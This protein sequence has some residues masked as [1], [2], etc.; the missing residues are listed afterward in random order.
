MR[1]KIVL[2]NGGIIV[3]LTLL[4][5]FLLRSSLDS[6]LSNPV[7]R[8]R[9][10]SR[11]LQS[12]ESRLLLDALK[13]ERWLDRMSSRSGVIEVFAAGTPAARS[14]AATTEANRLRDAAVAD[15]E[16][17][18]MG[19][20]LV[21]LVDADG[22]ALGRNGSELMR[23]ERFADVYPGLR[24]A[25][26]SQHTGSELWVNASRQEQML[27]S[28]APV[29]SVQGQLVGALLLG[30]P[31]NDDRMKRT[32]ELTLGGPLG[33]VM[34]GATSPVAYTS[35][36]RSAF[37][38]AGWSNEVEAARRGGGSFS[39]RV[40]GG[41]LQAAW[42]A[43]ALGPQVVLV[44][45]VAVAPVANVDSLLWSVLAVG[46]LGLALV[47]MTGTLLGNYI[48][49]PIAEIEDGLLSVMNGQ[50]ELRFDLE[51]SEL[52]G[53]TSR[54]NQLLNTLLDVP[55]EAEAEAPGPQTPPT[56]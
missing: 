15:P 18:V 49:R 9:E 38:S 26:T 24:A 28:F 46:A 54:L 34:G 47:F 27:V 2:V 8:R 41:F 16:L 33:L 21:L 6:A 20:S 52:G 3:V 56:E 55:E 23:G 39:S 36:P 43:P 17:V 35:G 45:A 10:L 29:R 1:T 53:L 19:P 31:L 48:S 37:V 44:G 25:L 30:T 22:V 11:G 12:A 50:R 4:S 42:P 5:F 32:S 7:E 14:Q 13:V 40:V 51:H